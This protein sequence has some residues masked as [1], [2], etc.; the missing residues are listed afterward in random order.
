MQAQIGRRLHEGHPR[1]CCR[2]YCFKFTFVFQTVYL[3]LFIFISV[4]SKSNNNS[5]K[6]IDNSNVNN[7]NN[8]NNNNDY[9]ASKLN[10]KNLLKTPIRE[11]R[12]EEI[13]NEYWHEKMLRLRWDDKEL[14][15]QGCSAW[16]TSQKNAPTHN[17]QF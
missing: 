1:C 15:E 16:L 9:E 8:N 2:T 3:G 12:K 7:N 6:N 10:I 14:D 11:E 4:N 5:T 17:S 13:Q